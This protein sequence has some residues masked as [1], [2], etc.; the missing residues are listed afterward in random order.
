[1]AIAAVVAEE[2]VVVRTAVAGAGVIS[3]A[4]AMAEAVAAASGRTSATKSDRNSGEVAPPSLMS[5]SLS[6]PR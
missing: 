6:S 2:A 1:V 4:T 3:T 5:I